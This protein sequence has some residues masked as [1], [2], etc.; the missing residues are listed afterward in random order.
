MKNTQKKENNMMINKIIL[1]VSPIFSIPPKSAAAIESWMYN[2]AK[3]LDIENRI[4]CIRN[5]GYSAHSVVNKYCEIERIKFGKVYTRLFKK[6][7]RLD[8]YSYADRIVKIKHQFSP[9]PNESVIFVHNHIKSFKKIIKKEGHNNVVL[10]MHNLYEP[11]DVPEDI[12]I[13]VPSH[14]MKNWYR[15][16]LPNALI[17]VVRNGFDGEIYAQPPEV[18][19]EDFGL[20]AEDKIVLFAGRIA[21]DKGLLELM[22]ACETFFKKGPR[23]KLVI[24]GDPNAALKGE[25]AQYQDEVKDYAKNLDEQCIFLGGVHPEKIRHY[26]SLADV[27]AV[28]SIA[29]EPFC[30]V[31]LEAMASGRPVI[32]SQRGAMVEFISHN[33]TGFIFREPLSPLS[34][35]EDITSALEHPNS[36]DIAYHAKKHAYDNF[37]W[38]I[39]KDELMRVIAKWYP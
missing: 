29:P 16:R 31:A 3:R 9:N 24:V 5:D 18:K 23:Y 22:Q 13:I 19:R 39:V 8:P 35:A 12:K 27:V 2:V 6:W 20:T 10:H 4:V 17:E 1:T 33:E 15:E 7:T 37:T 36:Q 26:Y 38:E 14:F 30:M 11:K 25:L 32:A 28:P 21:R 34:M